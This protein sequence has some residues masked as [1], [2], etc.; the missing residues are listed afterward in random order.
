MEFQER[1]KGTKALPNDWHK[2]MNEE[3]S[4]EFNHLH[5]RGWKCKFVR[6]PLFQRP[7]FIMTNLEETRVAI[8]EEDGT[9]N[10]HPETLLR[11]DE[12]RVN[13]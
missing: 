4:N 8:I 1:R 6:Q 2:Q 9:L 11:K 5:L 12:V 13:E 7:V 3:Q 10:L